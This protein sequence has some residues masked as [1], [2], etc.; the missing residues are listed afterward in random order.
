MRRLA[1]TVVLA[2]TLAASVPLLARQSGSPEI[3]ALLRTAVEQKQVPVAVAMVTDGRRTIYEGTVGADSTAIFAIASMTKPITSAALMQL[4]ES[5]KVTLDAP[6]ATYVPELAKVQVL[7]NGSLRPPKTQI[8]VRQL[9]SH[10][11]GF[12]Y[13]FMSKEI[14]DLV[15]SKRLPSAMG[16]D[17]GFMLAPLLFDPGT[18]WLYGISTDWVG[19]IVERVSGQSLEA[20]CRDH[21][22]N[23]LGM[24]DS[25]F[26]V[27]ESKQRRLV[28]L[29]VR[30]PQGGLE[31]QPRPPATPAKFY[32]GGGG[33]F[34]TA[35]DYLRFVRM[36]MAGGQLDGKR[37]LSQRSVDD[38]RR[39]QIGELMLRP[40]PSVMP[41]LAADNATLPGS[42]D[43]FGLGF[44]L[45]STTTGTARGT[46]TMAWAGI[47][48]TFFWIDTEKQI[49]AVLMTQMLP[50]LEPG[51]RKL[52]EDFDRAVYALKK[53]L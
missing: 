18:Q 32:S 16:Q 31:S 21:L 13:E 40:L 33:L 20:Y 6:A 52:L 15:A 19:R 35:P 1:P 22:F 10:T 49:G 3:D 27:P 51:P 17:D 25:S 38:M 36:M 53:P 24:P 7:D 37:V 48:N 2:A 34:S 39:N 4:V 44:A 42:L 23:P 29:W 11:S 43:K 12:G 41:A 5:G 45:N 28:P 9:L 30:T 26:D 14:A 46:N 50:G 8:T 47:Y